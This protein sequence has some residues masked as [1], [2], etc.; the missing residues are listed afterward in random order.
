M[1]TKT[2]TRV[3][4]SLAFFLLTFGAGLSPVVM[5]G[6]L[7]PP[8]VILGLAMAIYFLFALESAEPSR[9][10]R[11]AG[12][13]IA[14]FGLTFLARS[15][16]YAT[17]HF[18]QTHILLGNSLKLPAIACIVGLIGAALILLGTKLLTARKFAELK[19]MAVY[20]FAIF[21]ASL[22]MLWFLKLSG[23]PFSA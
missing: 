13:A 1:K 23:A 5:L 8:L 21:P 10:M 2:K 7:G 9:A 4:G 16:I 11:G 6:L 19:G 20:W 3:A 17:E 18:P 22:V 14:I 15:C 12:F